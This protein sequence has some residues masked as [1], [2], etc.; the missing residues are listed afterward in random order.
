V[1]LDFS[2]A[3][4]HRIE[5]G[6]DL[7][8]MPSRFEPC[9]L[10]QLYSLRYGT[11]PLVRATGG[12]ADTITDVT[13][14]SLAAGTA[15]GFSFQNYST[16]ALTETLERALATFADRATWDKVVATSMKQDW[17]WSQSA[18]QY[19]SLFEQAVNSSELTR[20]SHA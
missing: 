10:N 4:A 1:R 3:L 6:A 18:R 9:G 2:D 14:E 17:S 19:V 13:P 20:T 7:F 11:L 12:L 5:A 16:T 15:N 8:M